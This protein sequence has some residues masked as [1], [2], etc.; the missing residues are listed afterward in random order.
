MIRAR[1]Q[2]PVHSDSRLVGPYLSAPLEVKAASNV[3]PNLVGMEGARGRVPTSF[4]H[5]INSRDI[6]TWRTRI[7]GEIVR[8]G[9][10]TKA[11]AVK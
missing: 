10:A 5:H 9:G 6:Y 4:P 8:V 1:E 2:D 3:P 11:W 7:A